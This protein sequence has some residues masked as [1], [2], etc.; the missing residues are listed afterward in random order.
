MN[1]SPTDL[2]YPVFV[3]EGLTK[4]EPIDSLP[5]QFRHGLSDLDELAETL[6]RLKLTK[7]LLFGIPKTRDG[8]ASSAKKADGIVQKAIKSF[9]KKRL[10]V[11]S[12]VCLCQYTDH[13][14][15]R[16]LDEG[17]IN[18]EKSLKAISEIALSHAR[19]GT[20]YVAPSAVLLGQVSA[21]RTL[22]NENSL[23]RTKIMS[24]S[25]KFASSLYGP[26]RDAVE[27]S[28][29]GVRSYQLPPDD[30]DKALERIGAEVSEGADAVIVKPAM[31]YLDVITAAKERV[32][33]PIVAY[34]V[35]GEYKG[36]KSLNDSQVLYESLIAIKRAGADFI[37][38]YGA[39][40]VN[41]Q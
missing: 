34:Q 31:P 21:I 2:I 9:K 24:Y 32:D 11:I 40:E 26:F 27:S 28:Y 20:D 13:G 23:P 3:K 10:T 8:Q 15:C 38:S 35:S 4:K 39:I 17:T 16:L 41:E 18:E 14:E 12:D 33:V 6:T 7:V 25:A 5:G 1:L 30:R 22:L 36:I 37:I 29:N 19:A